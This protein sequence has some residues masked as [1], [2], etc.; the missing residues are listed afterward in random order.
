MLYLA[1]FYHN[2]SLLREAHNVTWVALKG[3]P[4]CVIQHP[5]CICFGFTQ[6]RA[7]YFDPTSICD[8]HAASKD[9][10]WDA[11]QMTFFGICLFCRS[12]VES[13]VKQC[14]ISLLFPIS[15]RLLMTAT[16]PV[17][18]RINKIWSKMDPQN[19][20]R[21][22]NQDAGSRHLRPVFFPIPVC[23]TVLP[24]ICDSLTYTLRID[25]I[26]FGLESPLNRILLSPRLG[27]WT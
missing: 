3:N 2:S 10:Y 15:L 12:D 24:F 7:H 20:I 18:V 11:T 14:Q 27:S 17:C 26:D 13:V 8:L 19:W 1:Y 23:T 25:S 22:C 5:G 4:G 9:E 16:G 21:P 6:P